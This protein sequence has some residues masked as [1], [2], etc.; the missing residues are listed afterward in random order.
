MQKFLQFIKQA[1]FPKK[2]NFILGFQS[3]SKKQFWL[4]AFFTLVAFISVLVMLDKINDKFLVSVPAD[5]GSFSEG[6]LGT[7]TFVN[8]VLAISDADEDL[9]SLVY[10]GL[11][12]KMPDGTLATDLAETYEIS[13]LDTK[14]TFTL[15][16]DLKFH[17]GDPITTDDIIFTINAIKD[18]IIKS[19]R[20]VQWDGIDVVKKD[21]YTI[22]FNLNQASASFLENTTVGILPMSLW[23][24]VG[25]SEFNSQLLNTKAIGSGP[26][27]VKKV[28][29]DAEGIP[30]I[31]T[32]KRF[33]HFSLGTPKI[34]EVKIISYANEKDIISALRNGSI[35]QAGGLSPM[36]TSDLNLHTSVLP[37]V[38]GLFFNTN[39]ASVLG[40]PSVRKAIDLALDR[41]VII[42]KALDGYGSP[43]N[44]PIPSSV[45]KESSENKINA[46]IDE[47]N[48]LLAKAGWTRNQDGYLQKGG[49]IKRTV[50][51]NK[52]KVT[53]TVST[54]T[55]GLYFSITTG[56]AEELKISAEEIKNQL[57]ALGMRIEIKVYETGQLNQ[58]IRSRKY[59]ALLFGQVVNHE[60]D[61]FAFWHSSQRA[62]PGLNIALYGNKTT[63]TLLENIQKIKSP[64]E[65]KSRYEQFI[66]LFRN[67]IPAVF[68]YSPKY[69]YAIK[70]NMHMPDN[71]EI[72]L[73]SNRFS[74]IYSWYLDTD[75]VWKIFTNQK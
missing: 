46:N 53:E 56:D 49:T 38:F 34:K 13:N 23:K 60:S 19:P 16:K 69:I 5:G 62:E 64:D 2:K 1:K 18:P 14:Y 31:Y 58:L 52:K 54:P 21:D 68:I 9:T 59:E 50:V 32:L 39:E 8:P 3:L 73:A 75:Q 55:Q 25:P 66:S 47:A 28:T 61:L 40:D 15:K 45:L 4:S 37:R 42:E 36:Y 26:Y 24:N 51:K 72:T 65:R 33:K 6:I 43:I 22:E 71:L 35:D 74:S 48:T 44:H 63:D 57:E 10:S 41:N 30:K 17:N 70:K 27:M 67:D 12:R 11:M 29:R 20:R 7:P